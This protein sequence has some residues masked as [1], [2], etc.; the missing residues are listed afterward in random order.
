MARSGQS[1]RTEKLQL[2]LNLE[3]LQ[4]IEDWRFAN[5]MPTRS[6]AVRELM[7]RGL[8][9][10]V[11]RASKGNGISVHKFGIDPDGRRARNGRSETAVG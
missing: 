7:R 5:R 4:M 3:E 1:K 9:Q 11:E 10:E 2:M 6:A 8:T